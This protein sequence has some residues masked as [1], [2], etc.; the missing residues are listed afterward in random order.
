LPQSWWVVS[1]WLPVAHA[2]GGG[3]GL[4]RATLCKSWTP[5]LFRCLGQMPWPAN[6]GTIWLGGRLANSGALQTATMRSRSSSLSLPAGSGCAAKGRQSSTAPCSP[7][8]SR[9]AGCVRS[10]QAR[11]RRQTGAHLPTWICRSGQRCRGDPGWSSFVL[12]FAAP[13]R[14]GLFSQDDQRCGF[15][16]APSPSGPDP[17]P[18]P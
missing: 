11:R 10:G 12:Y 5:T 8:P 18:D 16:Q 1:I 14:L 15:P 6:R 3:S 4:T 17:A 9:A 2:R 13:D 7:A